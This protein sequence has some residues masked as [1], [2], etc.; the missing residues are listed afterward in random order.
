MSK[1]TSCTIHVKERASIVCQ[2]QPIHF[3]LGLVH[4]SRPVS[5]SHCEGAGS[6]NPGKEER[7]YTKSFSGQDWLIE[8]CKRRRRVPCFYQADKQALSSSK[9]LFRMLGV[10][11]WPLTEY[12]FS[13]SAQQA[14]VYYDYVGYLQARG[15]YITQAVLH[16]P[17]FSHIF[18][19]LTE[20]LSCRKPPSLT[21][22]DCTGQNLS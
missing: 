5:C 7:G 2:C 20:P 17:H 1:K 21:T 22:I 19:P 18:K 15:P 11:L 4:N 16:R 9:F 13:D 8:G 6:G 10:W 3:K 14:A 12:E